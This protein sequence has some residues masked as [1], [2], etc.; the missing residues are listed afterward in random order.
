MRFALSTTQALV[1]AGVLLLAGSRERDT[2]VSQVSDSE[3][4]AGTASQRWLAAPG[5]AG[6]VGSLLEKQRFGPR[7]LARPPTPGSG[8]RPGHEFYF[9]R[10]I[11]SD[12]SRGF[13]GGERWAIDYPKADIQFLI[14]LRRLTYVNAFESDNAIALDDPDLRSYPF[15]YILE[16]GYMSL[17]PSEI[18]GLRSYLL[19]GGFLVVDDFW[20]SREWYVFESEMRRVFPDRPIVDIPLDHPIFHVFYDINELVQVPNVRQGQWAP[21]GGPTHERDGYYPHAKGILDEEGR[22]MVFINWNTDLGD[23]WEWADDPY[24]PLRFSTFAYEMGVNF[25]VYAMS[26]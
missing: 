10:G 6:A 4:A 11:Y 19:A 21:H 22:L 13:Y 2:P 23:A 15:L 26:H 14:G 7:S 20:G 18:D 3:S 17:T 9:T 25:I 8:P 12:G 16:V 1:V 24:Y 5:D